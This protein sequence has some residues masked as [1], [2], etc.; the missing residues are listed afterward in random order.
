[1][2]LRTRFVTD[3]MMATRL[4]HLGM[5]AFFGLAHSFGYAQPA[6]DLFANRTVIAGTNVTVTGSSVGATVEVGEPDI[7]GEPGGSSVWWSWT[8]PTNGV[9][10]ISTAGSTFDTLLGVYIG[11]SVSALSE[12]ASD[13]DDPDTG[14]LTSKVDFDVT[15][16]QT[17]QIVV[18][19]YYGDSGAIVLE[20]QL[21]PPPP[22]V[23]APA[24]ALLDLNDRLVHSTNYAGK[25]VVLNF[26]A[27][28]CGPC[29]AEIPDLITLQDKYRGDGLVVVGASVDDDAVTVANFE[30]TTPLNYLV[31]MADGPTMLAYG[32]IPYIPATF[33]I[34]RQNLIMKQYVG[35]QT[36]HTFEHQVIPLLYGNTRLTPQQSGNQLFLRWPT[37]AVGF[38]LESAS[39]T[40]P[41]WTAWPIAPTIVNGS[42]TVQVTLSPSNRLF[43]LRMPY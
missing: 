3:Y 19:G 2:L 18:D 11:S 23:P 20:L 32:G 17:Y 43:R 1:M 13:D 4:W 42:N 22:P 12:V 14:D 24:W 27:T 40:T 39:A 33:I 5:I 29:V 15:P 38:T 26:W 9:A 21:A 10:T 36:L 30:S 31:V 7:A 34:S 8:A 16:G 41:V 28:W 25:V 35:T 37:N 6:N